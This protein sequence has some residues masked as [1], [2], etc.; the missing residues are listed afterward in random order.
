L[1]FFF[2]SRVLKRKEVS[3]GYAPSIH[4]YKVSSSGSLIGSKFAKPPSNK[5]V[6]L[7]AIKNDV[8]KVIGRQRV[9]D[10]HK[11]LFSNRCG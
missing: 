8:Q 6:D 3:A 7:H 9:K 11:H 2:G 5:G 1:S 10:S 4:D